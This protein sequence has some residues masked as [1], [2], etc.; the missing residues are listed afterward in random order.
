MAAPTVLSIA[1]A[2]SATLTPTSTFTPVPTD[3]ATPTAT[4]TPTFLPTA[5]VTPTLLPPA[6]RTGIATRPAVAATAV[7][8]TSTSAPTRTVTQHFLVGRPVPS[9]APRTVPDPIYLYGTTQQGT[10]DVHHGEDYDENPIGTPLY[11]VTNG[12]VIV[13]GNDLQT[14]CGDDRKT[15]CGATTYP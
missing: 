10:Y 6:T 2:P 3:T 7:P 1:F 5:T 8:F 14:R 13:A 9:N 4:F 12:T 15:L 11:A